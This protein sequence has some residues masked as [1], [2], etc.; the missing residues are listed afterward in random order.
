MTELHYFRAFLRTVDQGIANLER[1]IAAAGELG[2]LLHELQVAG[3][4]DELTRAI[5]ALEYVDVQRL[6]RSEIKTKVHAY[7]E[8]WR[9]LLSTKQVEDGRRLLRETL[10]GPLRVHARGSNVSIR[11]DHV[12]RD[13]TGI[14]GV[15]PF[16]PCHPKL[17]LMRVSEG[18]PA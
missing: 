18:W 8:T 16:L 12:L 13:R 1:A 6:D 5:E 11:E 17:R 4:R 10:A 7:L 14:A 9:S 3:K 2:P 15:A